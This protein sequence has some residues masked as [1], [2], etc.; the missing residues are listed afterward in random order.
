MT[1]ITAISR[2][3]DLIPGSVTAFRAEA[4]VMTARSHNYEA[5]ETTLRNAASQV[6]W[7]GRAANA[8]AEVVSVMRKRILHV[9]DDFTDGGKAL[10]SFAH[11]LEWAQGEAERAITMWKKA[12]ADERAAAAVEDPLLKP[13]TS[14]VSKLNQSKISAY[15]IVTDAAEAVDAAERDMLAVLELL[16]VAPKPLFATT[17]TSNA[18][19]SSIGFLQGLST[20]TGAELKKFLAQH[21]NLSS[22]LAAMG[23][24]AVAAWWSTLTA[25]Q[26]S[27]LIKARPEVIGDLEGVPYTDRDEVNVSRLE[28]L[29]K[30]AREA[31]GRTIGSSHVP[32]S[33][34]AVQAAKDRVSALEWLLSEYGDGQGRNLNP[35]RLLMSLDTTA[36]GIPLAQLSVGNP[37]TA[38][39][40]NW[41]VPGMNSSLL[42]AK[43]YLRGAANMNFGNP[44]SATVVFL[45]YDSPKFP[46]EA[47]EVLSG[48]YARAGADH[49]TSA[50]NGY[51]AVR[52]EA[53]TTSQLNVIGHSYGTTTAA[54]AMA[55]H[56]LRIDNAIF[57]GSAGIDPTISAADLHAHSGVYATEASADSVADLGRATGRIDPTDS[58]FGA[59]VFG[60]DGA[61]LPNGSVLQ[62]VDG[63]DA[64]GS[65][66]AGDQNHYFGDRTETMRNIQRA[67]EGHETIQ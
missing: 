13:I 34:A 27:A 32:G 44:N 61:T 10:T 51:N 58:G 33:L 54:Y 15:A 8:F 53:G 64:V 11:T 41:M 42:E 59:H 55:A 2:A 37:D 12:D 63:H 31:A 57:V 5:L 17:S 24:P 29:L 47:S 48:T 14:H 45:G 52:D 67:L 30:E 18:I 46:S 66:A 28:K 40:A 23:A 39:T 19:R 62:A 9:A 6:E 26:R 16:T 7:E 60:S 43:D 22:E 1:A 49:L 21:P 20:L 25:A 36:P 38:T 50:L 3:T 56:D 65:S 4:N 35:P